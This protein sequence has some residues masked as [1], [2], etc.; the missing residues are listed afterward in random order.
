MRETETQQRNN[1]RHSRGPYQYLVSISPQQPRALGQQPA[2]DNL[3]I[4]LSICVV[5][6]SGDVNE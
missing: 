6:G 3:E 2:R 4:A 5:R 1:D